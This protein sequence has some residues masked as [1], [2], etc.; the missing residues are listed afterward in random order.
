MGMDV[1][2]I[3]PIVFG[4]GFGIVIHFERLMTG[5]AV[6]VV[7]GFFYLALGGIFEGD[8]DFKSA[9]GK[10]GILDG[11]DLIKKVIGYFR[12]R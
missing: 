2:S 10:L 4:P 9:L 5:A 7:L 1:A 3:P 6:I 12:Y 8:I 11:E